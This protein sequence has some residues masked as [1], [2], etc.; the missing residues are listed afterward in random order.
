MTELTGE[1]AAAHIARLEDRKARDLASV[2][3]AMAAS[4]T[5]ASQAAAA[6]ARAVERTKA[7]RPHTDGVE[8]I[9]AA[10]IK[11]EPINWLWPGWLARGKLHVL[12]GQA[13]TGKTTI[14]L[15]LA[16]RVTAGTALPGG[17]KPERGNVVVWSGEDDPADTL[18]PRL[19][20][21]GADLSRVRFVGEVTH[22]GD[23]CVFDP[24]RDVPELARA[25][26]GLQDGVSLLIV[27]PLVSAVA[28][29]SHK[30]AEV[31][32][33]LAPLV[34]LAA[35]IGAALIGITHFSKSTGG[36]DPLERV[37]GSLAFGALARIVYGTG[38]QEDGGLILARCK[39]NIGPDGGG[40]L[41]GF[42]QTDLPD[43][44]HV[45]ASRIVWG[46]AAEGTAREL[47]A[48]PEGDGEK[49]AADEASRWLVEILESGPVQVATIKREA[50]AAGLSWRT[51]EN[52]K[53]V[54][55]VSAERVSAGNDGCGFWQWSLQ[56][57]IGKTAEPTLC[58]L[59]VLPEAST[60]AGLSTLQD[61]KTARP[62]SIDELA[63]LGS[64]GFDL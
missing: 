59:A 34:E 31:R 57:G 10:G 14:A 26:K 13:G 8:L 28:G 3:A 54:A 5:L 30:N 55:G 40:W 53:R 46:A 11:P 41:Y 42:E 47:L 38:K 32:R 2:M 62:Q 33:G 61:R 60:G 20:A 35:S 18:V 49:S 9:D 63:V 19:I 29:D 17:W 27:D 23:V 12:A 1:P 21:A 52:A 58:G 36:R 50:K 6:T 39:S 64:D 43:H 16:A 25:I 24:A 56:G 15:D 37:T 4:P 22:G 48:D 45:K 44:P 7:P 51:V